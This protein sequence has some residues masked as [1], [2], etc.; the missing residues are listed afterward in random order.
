[1]ENEYW[2]STLEKLCGSV[3]ERAIS[4]KEGEYFGLQIKTPLGS[5]KI[6]WFLRDEEGNGPGAFEIQTLKGKQN[7]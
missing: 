2:T 4:D 1:M 7:G 5:H 6:I 3:I